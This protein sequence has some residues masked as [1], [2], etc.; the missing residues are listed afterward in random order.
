V[1]D[2][3]ATAALSPSPDDDDLGL[4]I[5]LDA[6]E[7]PSDSESLHF[8][9]HDMDLEGENWVQWTGQSNSLYLWSVSSLTGPRSANELIE[10]LSL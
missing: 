9:V 5:D 8:P 10:Q 2:D 3:Y 7:T 4:D 1:S 6:M